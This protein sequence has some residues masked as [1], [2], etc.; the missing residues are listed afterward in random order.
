MSREEITE[1]VD[2]ECEQF[3]VGGSILLPSINA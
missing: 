1:H 2:I 3:L